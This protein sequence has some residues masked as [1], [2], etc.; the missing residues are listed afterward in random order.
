MR[1]HK[2]LRVS[3]IAQQHAHH[4]NE[5]IE[6]VFHFESF[7]FSGGVEWL[8]LFPLGRVCAVAE[9]VL[10]RLLCRP[11][12]PSSQPGK[13]SLTQLRFPNP[14][15]SLR[16]L[17]GTTW[18]DLFFIAASPSSLLWLGFLP[19]SGS[20]LRPFNSIFMFCFRCLSN[21]CKKLLALHVHPAPFSRRLGQPSAAITKDPSQR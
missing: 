14:G 20:C 11:G 21:S 10:G 1:K 6:C 4:L 8:G 2:H 5:F 19:S 17:P 12:L 18:W 16:C 15:R 7:N 3:Y 9:L 13:S